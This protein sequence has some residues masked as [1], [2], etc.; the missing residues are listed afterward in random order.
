MEKICKW[1]LIDEVPYLDDV[2]KNYYTSC[3]EWYEVYET[4][5]YAFKYCPNCGREIKF[6]G[7]D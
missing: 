6:E 2:F 3:D 1:E 4:V 7:K 5:L